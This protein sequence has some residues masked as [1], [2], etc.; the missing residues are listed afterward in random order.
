MLTNLMKEVAYDIKV[1]GLS[2]FVQGNS[3]TSLLTLQN[4]SVLKEI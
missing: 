3:V 1:K 4:L 2:R